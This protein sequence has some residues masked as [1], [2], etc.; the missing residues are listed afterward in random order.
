MVLIVASFS[1]GVS[2]GLLQKIAF[3]YVLGFSRWF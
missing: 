2:D 1:N 3:F